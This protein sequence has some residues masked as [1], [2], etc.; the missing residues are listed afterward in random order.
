MEHHSKR[1]SNTRR[2]HAT[3]SLTF[4]A[5]DSNL[6]KS[7]PFIHEDDDATQE[8]IDLRAS[9][10]QMNNARTSQTS[11]ALRDIPPNASPQKAEH[12]FPRPKSLEP[13]QAAQLSTPAEDV[14]SESKSQQSQPASAQ[15]PLEQQDDRS[16]QPPKLHEQLTQ[17]LASILARQIAAAQRPDSADA[18]APAKR[19]NR[20]LGRN[21]SGISQHHSRSGA[22]SPAPLLSNDVHDSTSAA[23]GFSF[24]SRRDVDA[25]LPPGTQLGYETAEAEAHRLQMSKKM[26]TVFQDEALG[27][28]IASLGT[29]KDS[30]FISQRGVVGRVKGRQRNR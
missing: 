21:L 16:Q 4:K 28:R 6:P 12:E 30:E 3:P 8:S 22:N 29:V 19:K 10:K 1:L 23:D 13:N 2:R 5:S 18:P 25:E 7:G 24:A 20:P 15:D 14:P 27:T 11:H 26:G 9:F 17:D